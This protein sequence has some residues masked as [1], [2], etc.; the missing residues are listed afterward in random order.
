M[1][2]KMKKFVLSY[3]KKDFSFGEI[4]L[5]ADTRREVVKK[6][7]SMKSEDKPQ[8]M[9]N[10]CSETKYLMDM[11]KEM[12][13]VTEKE[14]LSQILGSLYGQ[15]QVTFDNRSVIFEDK[16]EK[17]NEITKKIEERMGDL[18]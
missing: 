3:Q 12:K 14:F 13:K 4:I 1:E 17:F 6:F 7:E 11:T 15:S 9:M 18:K 10:P 2:N 16:L 8:D 5:E